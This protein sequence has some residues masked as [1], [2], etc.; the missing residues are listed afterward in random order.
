MALESHIQ[1]AAIV[2]IRNL[3][4][5]MRLRLSQLFTVLNVGLMAVGGTLTTNV[6]YPHRAVIQFILCLGGAIACLVWLLLVIRTTRWM[7]FWHSRLK[8]IEEA[9]DVLLQTFDDDY[10]RV[11]QQGPPIYV[12]VGALIVF[13]VFVW[14]LGISYAVWRY[15]WQI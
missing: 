13:F 12:T 4:V 7:Q 1:Y 5:D 15:L 11:R 9:D 3:E 8:R 6:D 14:I 2:S 10:V